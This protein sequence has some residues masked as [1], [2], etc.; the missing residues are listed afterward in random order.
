MAKQ[1]RRAG[2]LSL[3]QPPQTGWP[4][5]AC[6][7]GARGLTGWH[8]SWSPTDERAG[9]C[10]HPPSHRAPFTPLPPRSPASAARRAE[11]LSGHQTVHQ[12]GAL[13]RGSSV[14]RRPH[15]RQQRVAH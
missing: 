15:P 10:E 14:Q 6:A 5:L 8:N 1:G 3:R 4:S 9:R 12:P 11:C 2:R 7:L 13:G